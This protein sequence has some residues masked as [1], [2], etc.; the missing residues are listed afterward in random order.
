MTGLGTIINVLCIVGGGLAGHFAGSRLKPAMQETVMTM[1]G[2][3]VM[4]MG[5]G[6]ALEKM[7][8]I[9]DGKLSAVNTIMMIVS[10]ALGSAVGEALQIEEKIVRF[11]EW[12]KVKSNSGGDNS[13]VNGFVTASCTVC[14]GAM[15]VIGAIQDGTSGNYSTL[16]AKGL[17]DAIIICIMTASLGKGC[18]FSAI[19][20]GIIQG[21]ITAIAFFTGNFMPQKALDNLSFVGSVLIFCVGLNLVR[22][23]QIRVANTLP[24]IVVASIWG[25][26]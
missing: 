20:V 9:A 18:I 15:A 13:F 6:G 26:F 7:L 16:L 24:A 17:I 5:I 25:L 22:K 19:P 3:G 14:I 10:L 1:T 12:L 8:V 21:I 11:G 4:V 2:I 23:K